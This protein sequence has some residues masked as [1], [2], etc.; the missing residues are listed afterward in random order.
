MR[1]LPEFVGNYSWSGP[2]KLS[3]DKDRH[4]T[5]GYKSRG[6]S[7]TRMGRRNTIAFAIMPADERSFWQKLFKSAGTITPM[8]PCYHHSLTATRSSDEYATLSLRRPHILTRYLLTQVCHV[9]RCLHK[10]G[11]AIQLVTYRATTSTPRNEKTPEGNT[12]FSMHRDIGP[13]RSFIHP[14]V[15][16]SHPASTPHGSITPETLLLDT[17]ATQSIYSCPSSPFS[18]GDHNQELRQPE[19]SHWMMMLFEIAEAGPLSLRRSAQINGRSSG[20]LVPPS[21]LL[22]GL[23]LE[24]TRP[25]RR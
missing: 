10:D 16:F 7:I 20:A 12:Q 25:V 19:P 1:G 13:H 22:L 15:L 24:A 5:N 3:R 6:S 21:A 23:T 8:L 11:P 14:P 2:I 9:Q 18:A 17:D 4:N